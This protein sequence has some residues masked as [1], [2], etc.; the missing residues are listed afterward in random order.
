M[1]LRL[2]ITL[3][4]YYISCLIERIM[5]LIMLLNEYYVI[6]IYIYIAISLYIK[7]IYTLEFISYIVFIIDDQRYF[8]KYM[9]II[10][11]FSNYTPK[12]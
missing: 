1:N 7:V 12:E 9:F 3:Y 10:Y 4:R 11:I 8:N 2:N 5:C 6:Y